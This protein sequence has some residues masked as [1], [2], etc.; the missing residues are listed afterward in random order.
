M[1]MMM[2]SSGRR[3]LFLL[4]SSRLIL[5]ARAF[6]PSLVS[7]AFQPGN[8]FLPSS[9]TFSS[10]KLSP[11]P[12]A[13]TIMDGEEDPYIRLE[14]VESPESIAFAESANAKCLAELGDP[15]ET[16]TYK[17]VLTALQ[18]D[19]RIPHVRM[20]GYEKDTG[21]MLLY[22]FWRDANSPKGI[23]RKTTMQQYQSADTEWTTVLDLDKLAKEE[24]IS[25]VWKGY[26][27]LPRSLD[28]QSGGPM[29]RV[30]RVLL[31]LSRGGADA[32]YLRE[33]DLLT[34]S[35]VDAENDDGFSLPEAKT[36]ASY[37][38][39]DVLLV[40]ADTGEESMTSSGY[41]R[42][43][44]EWKRGTK[45]EDAPIVFE[46]EKTDVSCGQYLLDES[47]REGGDVYEVQSR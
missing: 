26:T 46:G 18:S 38:S 12:M 31:N 25:W 30:T 37:K 32:T 21:D 7:Q 40:G 39:R 35:F 28:S 47:D 8:L 1:M 44:R 45:I 6:T 36:R 34:E 13:N 20:L 29:G 42:T 5:S 19:E 9:Y 14:E 10:T 24:D 4:Q 3:A 15:S 27:A 22:N 23:W 43:V 16:E 33:F 11:L 17:R 41:H 2:I